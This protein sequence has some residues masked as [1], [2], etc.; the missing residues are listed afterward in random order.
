MPLIIITRIVRAILAGAAII[1]DG[2]ITIKREDYNK[3]LSDTPGQH[4]NMQVDENTLTYKVLPF[5]PDLLPHVMY[6]E[7]NETESVTNDP[8]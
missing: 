7:S 1:E 2:S 6:Q 5:N 3:A 4:I 8:E